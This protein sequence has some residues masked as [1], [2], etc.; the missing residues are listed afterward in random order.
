MRAAGS[1]RDSDIATA[2]RAVLP[3]RQVVT[4]PLRRLAYGTDASFYRLTPEVVAVVESESQV[5]A[6]LQ[7]ARAARP[8]GP[9]R[10]R[11]SGCFP[12]RACRLLL[13][14][15]PTGGRWSFQTFTSNL[16]GW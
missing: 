5:Q 14:V 16:H 7:T 3:W 2:L 15:R 9:G 8:P 1:T 12:C 6:V 11:C 13:L 4:D 10:S